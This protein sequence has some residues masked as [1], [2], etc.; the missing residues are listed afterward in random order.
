MNRKFYGTRRAKR[1]PFK[2]GRHETGHSG[3]GKECGGHE[4]WDVVAAGGIVHSTGQR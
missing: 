2:C 3:N 1:L 4:E